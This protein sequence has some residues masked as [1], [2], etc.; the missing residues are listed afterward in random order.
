MFGSLYKYGVLFHNNNKIQNLM[1]V[2]IGSTLD[3]GEQNRVINH[4]CVGSVGGNAVEETLGAGY[5]TATPSFGLRTFAKELQFVQP[6]IEIYPDAFQPKP[7]LAL[8][9]PTRH[10][11]TNPPPS[12]AFEEDI[13][14][15]KEHIRST[16]VWYP[17]QALCKK[18][19][20]LFKDPT[21]SIVS[22]EI[23]KEVNY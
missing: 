2:L 20:I 6:N 19:D 9:R 4:I 12:N 16:D 5:K 11:S 15:A 17:R 23:L 18:L 7:S 1:L 21:S 3:V 10:V 8:S 22:F 13:R 14:P